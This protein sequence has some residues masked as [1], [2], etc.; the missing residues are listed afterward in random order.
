MTSIARRIEIPAFPAGKR[1]AVTTSWDDGRVYDRWVVEAFNRLGLKGTFNLNSGLLGRSGTPPAIESGG[2]LDAVEIA[3]L[4]AGHE[5]A[6]HTVSHPWL[7]RLDGAQIAREVLDDR[8]ALETLVGYPVRGMAYPFGTYNQQVITLLR[9]LG[10]VYSRTTGNGVTSFPP[11]E[12]LTWATTMHARATDPLP[13]PTRW[14][15]F[16]GN[17]RAHGVFYSWGHS[18]E[19]AKDPEALEPLFAP[20][21][22]K[23]DVWYAT[24]IELF[25]YEAARQRLVLAADRCSAFNPSALSVTISL[26]GTL[27]DLPPGL[28]QLT[29]F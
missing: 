26:D 25:D 23:P 17:P 22:G 28:S 9:E 3:G 7:E 12:P 8:A 29:D 5:V 2:Y 1:I 6:V 19:F 14:E 16:Y 10:I 20:L 24:N 11:A 4:F 13:L 15:A 18:Y 21:A 27:R